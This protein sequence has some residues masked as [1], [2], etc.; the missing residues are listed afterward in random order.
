MIACVTVMSQ[1]LPCHVAFVPIWCPV[2]LMNNGSK[3]AIRIWC[4]GGMPFSTQEVPIVTFHK[5]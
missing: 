3:K 1:I 4:Q 2:R 5:E